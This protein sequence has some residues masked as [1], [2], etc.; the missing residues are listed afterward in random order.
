M[1]LLAFLLVLPLQAD[2]QDPALAVRASQEQVSTWLDQWQQDAIPSEEAEYAF[3]RLR[4]H[5]GKAEAV[6]LLAMLEDPEVIRRNELMELLLQV[7]LED[8]RELL[9]AFALDETRPAFERG[10][11]AEFLL[12]LDG[13]EAFEAL[14][15]SLHVEAEPP[16]LRRF[17]AGW[18]ESIRTED[19]PI[20]EAF[21]TAS[22][23]E[24]ATGQ[25]ALQLWARHE[26]D[27]EARRRIYLLARDASPS[28][29]ATA[30][31]V[32]ARRGPDPIIAA[33]LME[34]L[35]GASPD[36][37]RLARRMLPAFAGPE[38]LF[39]AYRQRA[40]GRS[41]N[42]RGR[43]MIEIAGLSVPEAQ[44][45]AMRWLVDGGWSTG[46]LANQV[47]TLLA[48]SSAVD[49][50]LPTL[51]HHEGIPDRVLFPL[52]IARAPFQ[53]D[54]YAYLRDQFPHGS[55]VLQIQ[56]LRSVGVRGMEEDLRFLR[57]V[58]ESNAYP[59][60][61]RAAAAEILIL[62]PAAEE[63]VRNRFDRPLPQDYELAAAWVRSLAGS[64]RL[65]WRDEAV[66][67]ATIAS[68]FEDTDERRGLR[69]EAWAA[70]GRT[71]AHHQVPLLRDRLWHL[72]REPEAKTPEGEEWSTLAR[73]G[74]Q[75]PELSAVLT[76][77]KRCIDR[78]Q[79]NALPMPED[80]KLA[81]IH[82]DPLLIAA[83]VLAEASPDATGPWLEELQGRAL[84]TL[85]QL[86]VL[87]LTAHLMPTSAVKRSA[88]EALLHRAEEVQHYRRP[89]V[90]AF[91]PEGAGWMLL[92]E[93]LAE[94]LLVEEV[95][96]G[97][98]P[99]ADLA[100]LLTGYA[101]DTILRQ[102]ADLVELEGDLELALALAERRVAHLPLLDGAHAHMALLL[103]D[104]QRP[105]QAKRAWQVVERLAPDR[106]D[107]WLQARGIL[108]IESE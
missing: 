40:Q 96:V 43:W 49:A 85:D 68:G 103:G 60:S 38:A 32:L 29:R 93:R 51:L 52:A 6:R 26:T 46:T 66:A 99:A 8:S 31:E 10:R 20:L 70:M 89:L 18:R 55:S 7:P 83:S 106:S 91:V 92:T 64:S 86:R 50:L 47:V 59:S 67:A 33:M 1:N 14:R 12:L 25:F 16:Y 44:D 56:I 71:G 65:E 11:V 95:R 69:I 37:R 4:G 5:L 63:Y 57:E 100:H 34:E 42:L 28:Y 54:A 94:R 15:T 13:P 79:S 74:Q 107:L 3:A 101:D 76:A 35:D 98:R 24:S 78:R 19:L 90:E 30:M 72:L 97:A 88:L 84:S 105:D 80:L 9:I 21:A 27:P 75:F 36:L 108:G 61:T 45:E 39:E 23:A 17:F 48:R 102:A 82:N 53:P 77:L 104:L 81:D 58:F 2:A 22:P 41:V 87:A 73:L 62:A